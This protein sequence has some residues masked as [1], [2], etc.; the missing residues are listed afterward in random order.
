MHDSQHSSTPSEQ[1]SVET[2]RALDALA[3][4]LT[5]DTRVGV[6]SG[7]GISAASGIPTFRGEDGLWKQYRA[8][9]LATPQAFAAQPELVW[10]WYGWRRDLVAAARPNPAHYALGDL[11]ARVQGLRI[12]T[13]NVD[14]LHALALRE[15]NRDPDVEVVEV[16]GSIWRMRC[17]RCGYER[18]DRR[19]GPPPGQIPRCECRGRM[20]PG[21]VWFGEMLPAHAMQTAHD[22]AVSCDVLLVVGTSALVQP[23]AS[24]A[25]VARHKG[26]RVAEFNLQATP[27]DGHID[28]AVHAP[29]EQS[30]PA[31]VQRLDRSPS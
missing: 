2:E 24:W 6:L 16:H 1:F 10:E 18:E 17:E 11:S 12:I 27:L 29:A 7:A 26:A 15:Q 8:E 19:P 3:G 4:I 22:I 9:E 13:Q 20:R 5:A 28:F 31:L 23:A 21:V 14:G 25:H 30:L